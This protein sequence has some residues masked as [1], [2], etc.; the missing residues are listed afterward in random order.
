MYVQ[1]ADLL[2]IAA[3]HICLSLHSVPKVFMYASDG[4]RQTPV[5]TERTQATKPRPA[6]ER[7]RA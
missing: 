4:H 5:L 1:H 2:C 3:L 7:S 6:T